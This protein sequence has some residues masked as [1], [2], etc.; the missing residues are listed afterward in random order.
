MPEIGAMKFN[1]VVFETLV[2][3]VCWAVSIEEDKFLLV[4]FVV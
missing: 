1:V 3:L 2:A 4:E